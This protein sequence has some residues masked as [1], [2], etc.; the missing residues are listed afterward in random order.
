MDFFVS[1]ME[2]AAVVWAPPFPLLLRCVLA[3]PN[4]SSPK[5]PT[6]DSSGLKTEL[7]R[8]GACLAFVRI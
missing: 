5:N 4:L 2:T 8:R 6:Q 7:S 3:Y 1:V